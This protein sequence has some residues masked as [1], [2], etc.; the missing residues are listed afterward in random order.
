MPTPPHS[1]Q[2]QVVA[3]VFSR[4][5]GSVPAAR[6][7]PR[8]RRNGLILLFALVPAQQVWAATITVDQAADGASQ[9]GA[10]SLRDALRAAE[11]DSAVQGCAAGSGT[12]VIRF[13]AAI[14]N[15][16]LLDS[17]GGALRINSPV[18]LDGE[19]RRVSLS[20]PHTQ[21]PFHVIETSGEHPLELRWITVR[22]GVSPQ[23][24]GIAARGGG[25]YSSGPLTLSDCIIEGNRS[26]NSAAG[27]YGN[28]EVT[29][30]RTRV[31]N[32]ITDWGNGAGIYSS[33]AA[34]V[35]DSWIENNRNDDGDGGGIYAN[36]SLSIVRTWVSGNQAERGEGGG[37]HARSRI[38][39]SQS[40]V[41][42]NSA[43]LGGG[44]YAESFSPDATTVSDSEIRDNR[45]REGG[46][47]LPGGGGIYASNYLTVTRSRITGN[48]A[49][50]RFTDGHSYGGGIRAGVLELV[51]STIQNNSVTATNAWA[52]GLST[53][54]SRI[55]GSTIVG[56]ISS[57]YGGGLATGWGTVLTNSTV[58]GN[59]AAGA[60][61]AGIYVYG[62]GSGAQDA[63]IT[64]VNSTV[65]NN[66][67]ESP[68][69]SR[70]SGIWMDRQDGE[71]YLLAQS[72][73][74]YGN[75]GSD[76]ASPT[77]VV[78]S[79][80]HNLIGSAAS[81]VTLP[82]NTLSC[83]PRMDPL[84]DNGGPTHSHRLPIDSCAID[85]GD[86]P[87]ALT[88]DQRGQRFPRVEGAAADI[89]A[90]EYH[91]RIFADLFEDG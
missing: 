15:I 82:A 30:L 49:S 18:I 68:Q 51:D 41:T 13:A 26:F 36:Q 62:F 69:A 14:G 34:T 78:V 39:V 23:L 70:H 3:P 71:G 83:D 86:N 33:R 8:L 85:A 52:G 55:R 27:V 43:N 37:I 11:L 6:A 20:R 53:G 32:N 77:A 57:G 61:G 42:D 24:G 9:P 40:W 80:S 75:D 45:V 54:A 87:A 56:N 21:T 50:N 46:S 91:D 10:C 84:E 58:S 31:H 4:E 47:S 12:D 7:R 17:G 25:I 64:L 44:I 72:N 81:S 60:E 16:D 65:V 22:G 88:F 89:G 35:T 63:L 1:A 29:L 76:I 28:S 73:L 90:Y 5:L 67:C 19:G 79:G 74:V 2:S 66:R 48:T 38:A 59:V